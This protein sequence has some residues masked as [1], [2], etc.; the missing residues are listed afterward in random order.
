MPRG[1]GYYRFILLST[2]IRSFE[3]GVVAS[4]MPAIRSGLG[5]TYTTQGQVAGSPDYG[6]VP[7]GLLAMAVFKRFPP[8]S[9]P[10]L[11]T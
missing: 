8:F 9:A 1:R 5:L 11:K 3:A 4:M 6:I 10:R 7:S 2:A